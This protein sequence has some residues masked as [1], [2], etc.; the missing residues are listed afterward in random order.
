[1]ADACE[2]NADLMMPSGVQ[3]NIK[4]S[5]VCV[6]AAWKRGE[7]AGVIGDNPVT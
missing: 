2:L 4:L 1:M 3:M 5:E 7:K 6:A